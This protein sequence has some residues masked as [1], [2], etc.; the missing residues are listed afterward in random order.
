MGA[1]M[2]SSQ[3]D[4]DMLGRPDRNCNFHWPVTSTNCNFRLSLKWD[5]S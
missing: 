2:F 4:L 1:Y 3:S 5:G